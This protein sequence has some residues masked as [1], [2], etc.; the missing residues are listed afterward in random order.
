MSPR[1][2]SGL[3]AMYRALSAI[4]PGNKGATTF[5]RVCLPPLDWRTTTM[6]HM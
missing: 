1:V 6:E 5:D 3:W 4:P 2:A